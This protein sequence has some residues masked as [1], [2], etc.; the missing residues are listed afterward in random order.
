MSENRLLFVGIFI[1]LVVF[2][3]LILLFLPLID[4]PIP[5]SL[6]KNTHIR[7]FFAWDCLETHEVKFDQSAL[8]EF[9][10]HRDQH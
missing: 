3:F 8:K 5:A 9:L 4:I 10:N 2:G 1:F 7:R 6:R